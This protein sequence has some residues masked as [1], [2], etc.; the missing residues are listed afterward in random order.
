MADVDLRTYTTSLLVSGTSGA[1]LEL[2]QRVDSGATRCAACF[3][4]LVLADSH[5]LN[6]C[7]PQSAQ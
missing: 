3:A 4:A 6:V 5:I 7:L 1:V 2:G